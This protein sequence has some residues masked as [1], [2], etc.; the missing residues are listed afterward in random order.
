MAGNQLRNHGKTHKVYTEPRKLNRTHKTLWQVLFQQGRQNGRKSIRQAGRTSQA[1]VKQNAGRQNAETVQYL[2][3]IVKPRKQRQAAVQKRR[4]GRQ[5]R[6]Q[7][8]AA[9]SILI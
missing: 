8:S 1:G 3:S 6:R 4:H 5:W 7:S 9:G 2:C